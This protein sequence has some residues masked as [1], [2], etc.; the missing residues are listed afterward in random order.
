KTVVEPK[1]FAPLPVPYP[2]PPKRPYTARMKT[3]THIARTHR[4]G[5][6]SQLSRNNYVAP[7]G[8]NTGNA[9]GAGAPKGNRNARKH[10][11]YSAEARAWHAYVCSLCDR[12]R[13]TANLINVMVAAGTHPNAHEALFIAAANGG[14][15]K[16]RSPAVKNPDAPAHRETSLRGRCAGS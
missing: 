3:E 11:G 4:G 2:T 13:D 15:R 6:P 7:K 10:G 1:F 12:T 5:T 14:L 9:K 16:G 8:P